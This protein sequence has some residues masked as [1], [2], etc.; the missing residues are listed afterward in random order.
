[1]LIVEFSSNLKD[2]N[3]IL[4]RDIHSN[5]WNS[6]EIDIITLNLLIQ[7]FGYNPLYIGQALDSYLSEI[8]VKYYDANIRIIPKGIRSMK[9][10][11]EKY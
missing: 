3:K 5:I 4:Y 9:Y 1:M 11:P 7:N 6:M 10:M 8:D 2:T